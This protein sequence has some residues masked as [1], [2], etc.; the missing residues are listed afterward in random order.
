MVRVAVDVLVGRVGVKLLRAAGHEVVVEA[1]PAEPDRDWF[2]RAQACGAE[3]VIAADKDLRNLCRE[4]NV[5]FFKAKSGHRGRITAE[6][7][8]Q[9]HVARVT[10]TITAQHHKRLGKKL[11]KLLDAL[12]GKQ[13]ATLNELLQ[14]VRAE[15]RNEGYQSGNP[16]WDED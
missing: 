16:D 6:R 3:V 8:I 9:Q 4:H 10:G 1:Q 5:N 7:F 2:A 14:I 12:D 13:I 15:G 11:S